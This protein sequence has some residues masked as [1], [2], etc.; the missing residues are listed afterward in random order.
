MKKLWSAAAVFAILA[1]MVLGAY[2]ENRADGS[3]LNF[4]NVE[5]G[6]TWEEVMTAAG[7]AEEDVLGDNAQGRFSS[8]YG[9]T[10]YEV[11]GQRADGVLFTM[12]DL[13]GGTQRLTTV[14]INY[15]DDADMDRVLQEMTK[16]YGSP[17]PELINYDIFS[18]ID[19]SGEAKSLYSK[20]YAES[21]KMKIW[22]GSPLNEVVPKEQEQAYMKTWQ[23]K[24]YSQEGSSSFQLG[25]TDDQWDEFTENA[26]MI[27]VLWMNEADEHEGGNRVYLNAYID[28]AFDEITRRIS[29]Q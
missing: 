14:M 25:L 19:S 3:A 6:M 7:I 4:P 20:Q 28:Q 12:I 18:S 16:A 10:E 1:V 22:A 26:R 27:M 5:W 17:V 21:E 15:P 24:I 29:E 2:T 13:G 11:F 9:V 23:E 8:G